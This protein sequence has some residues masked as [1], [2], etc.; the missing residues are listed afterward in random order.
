MLMCTQIIYALYTYLFYVAAKESKI[1]RYIKLS[2][3]SKK[4]NILTIKNSTFN[5]VK[6]LNNKLITT[7]KFK[8]SEHLAHFNAKII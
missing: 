4:Q 6:N 2:Q 7:S 1:G 3:K 5:Y 8:L